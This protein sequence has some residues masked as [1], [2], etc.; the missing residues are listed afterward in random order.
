MQDLLGKL[1]LNKIITI[2]INM[3]YNKPIYDISIN[4]A[5][6]LGV[7]EVAFVEDPAIQELFIAM[8]NEQINLAAD[9]DKMIV[10]GPALVPDRL[11][12]RV[13][14][15]TGAEYYI[16]FSKE[17]I[18]QIVLR[19]FTQNKQ[20]NFNLEHN[21][22]NDVQG[23]ILES[24]VVSDPTYDKS[25]LYGFKNLPI[26]TWMVSVKVEDETFWKEYVKTGKVRG[27]SIEGA[28]GQSLAE[29]MA[30]QELVEPRSGESKDEYISRCVAYHVGQ[31]GMEADQAYAICITKFEGSEQ[32]LAESYTDYPQSVS[33]NAQRAL[34]YAEEN[35]WGTCGT[36]VGKQ[37][38]NQLAK[39]EPISE[40]TISRM[41]SFARHLQ[42]DDKELGDGC[43]KLMI[44]AWGGKQGI[45]WAQRK[46]DEI[47][48][49]RVGE[50]V[51]FD[52]DGVLSTRL[53]KALAKKEIQSGSTVYIISARNNAS[54]MY[55][56][57]DQLGIPRE[58][59][60]ATGS[61]LK[62]AE[63]IKE[64]G[65][66]THYDNNRMVRR[67]LPKGVGVNFTLSEQEIEILIKAAI[68]E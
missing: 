14:P 25:A 26:G 62:K 12:Y 1:E 66:D 36:P 6:H 23:V 45:E 39:R 53:G 7:D 30:N 17:V 19:Y 44:L 63:K 49:L 47:Q 31:E 58:R 10:T 46:L 8:A 42:Y 20:L 48:R 68:Q 61:N 22:E 43:A 34:N 29:A 67:L 13:H 50:K 15:K 54:T 40:E 65:I 16:R 59:V 41:A 18:E 57:A 56:V 51:S 28:F 32:E 2:F 52:W 27:F 55:S 24:W 60:I 37:R 38:A 21:K 3:E 35:G 64:L 33:D 4:E 5:M 11:I 9:N